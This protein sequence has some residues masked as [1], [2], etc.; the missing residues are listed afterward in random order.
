[1]VTSACEA[2]WAAAEEAANGFT[3]P[4]DFFPGDGIE[5]THGVSVA[6]VVR[7]RQHTISHRRF[8]EQRC[9]AL[10]ANDPEF[11]K[12]LALATAGAISDVAPDFVANGQPEP[13]RRLYS[14]LPH[15]FKKHA[16]ALW[17]KGEALIIPLSVALK[18]KVHFSPIHWTAQ[19]GKPAGRFLGDLTNTKSGCVVND[20]AAKPL[21]EARYGA[22]TL[23]TIWD[24]VDDIL[25]AARRAGGIK[26][27]RLWKED[28]V[29]AFNRF[30]FNPDSVQLL[31]FLVSESH[32]LLPFTGVFGWQG[33]PSVWAVFGRAISRLV[34]DGID[35]F[36]KLYVDDFIGIGHS[37]TVDKDQVFAR[38]IVTDTFGSDA[39]NEEKSVKACRVCDCLGWML[40]LVS[41]SVYPNEKGIRKL[42]SCFFKVD[43]KA[44]ITQHQFQVMASLACRYSAG[45]V[46]T[47]AFVHP[48]FVGASKTA[49][50][51]ATSEVKLAIAVWKAVALVSL[52]NPK[53]LAVPL[54]S[55]VRESRV[56]IILTT[57]AGPEGL[58]V[59]ITSLVGDLVGY[60]SYK[61]PFAALESKYQNLR[62]FC[63][64][65]LGVIAVATCVPKATHIGW[66]GDNVS[67][68]KWVRS[69]M[70]MSRAAQAAFITFSWLKI[71]SGIDFSFVKHI[72]GSSMGDVDN[73]SRFRPTQYDPA[74]DI[75]EHLNLKEIDKL[76]VLCN[77][78]VEVQCLA[79]AEKSLAAIIQQS[80]RVFG[81]ARTRRS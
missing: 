41:E 32:V 5:F 2:T 27:I 81:Y 9:R 60:I 45:L 30:N 54:A 48:F 65:L 22:V 66:F 46:G 17:V 37:D 33:S 19:Q 67:A 8:N 40:D 6:D 38:K 28:V 21:I 71:R 61:L 4:I 47:R 72:P 23:P 14:V 24:I 25:V 77:P 58:G 35:G 56:D 31:A 13:L 73:L 42:I 7:T 12:L 74:F 68:L 15:T 69:N 36:M 44:R 64:A 79:N 75:S 1:M 59:V 76:F 10:F 11:D 39:I 80:K 18:L 20:P 52:G 26:H 63:G 62:E 49:G 78:L 51:H 70:T 29:G 3:F 34:R 50:A 16:H 57:D 55:F 53:T 43:T